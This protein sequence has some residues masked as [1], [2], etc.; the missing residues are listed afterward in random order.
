[1]EHHV[2][3]KFNIKKRKEKKSVEFKVGWWKEGGRVQEYMKDNDD[4]EN[5]KV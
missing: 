1:M 3:D 5:N 2:D 4:D